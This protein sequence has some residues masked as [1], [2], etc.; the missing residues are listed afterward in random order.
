MRVDLHNH[1]KLCNH[2]TGEMEEY[3]EKAI[4]EGIDIFGFSDHAPMDFD[5]RYRM[6]PNDMPKYEKEVRELKKRYEDKIEILLGYEVDFLPGLMRDDVLNAEVDYLIGSVHFLPKDK[7]LWGFDNPEFIGEYK[8]ADIDKIYEDYFKAVEEMAK[9]SHFQIAAHLDLIKVFN[10]RPKKDIRILAKNA[11]KAIKK[12]NM[13][14][15]I[16]AAGLR[17]P[18][19]EAYPGKE[20]LQS[21][22]DMDIPITFASDAHAPNQVGFEKDGIKRLAVEA[23]FD[24]QAVF[25]DKEMEFLPL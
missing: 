11:L 2:A 5:K 12:S 17:K 14:V 13:A 24:K 15:E 18:V 19:K 6:A 7:T 10:F 4:E 3:V 20:L 8:N 22:R 9:S 1:T 25:R 16:S 23:G 21:I